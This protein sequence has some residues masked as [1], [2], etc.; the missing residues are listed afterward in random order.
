VNAEPTRPRSATV[1]KSR[2]LEAHRAEL[3]SGIAWAAADPSL[4]AASAR[5]TAARR[6]FVL[7]AAT[8]FTYASLLAAK[9]SAALAKVTLIDGT[10]VRP[11]DILSDVHAADVLI[12]ISL[13]P[14]RRY[15]IDAA[16]PFVQAG[17]QLLVVTDAPDAPLV[18][19]AAESVVIGA[20]AD[21][22]N[23]ADHATDPAAAA[24]DTS[25]YS[26]PLHPETPGASPVVIAL[27]IDILT[28]LSSASAK[29]AGRRIAARDRLATELGLFMD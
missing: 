29:G 27:V 9:L 16:V 20:P 24:A 17:G 4:E 11:L 13:R 25:G 15:T 2:L 7:G 23:P 19:W 21:D 6:R 22:P 12:A 8:S 3:A 1:L 26:A 14:Y 10:I 18:A 28:A 5:I